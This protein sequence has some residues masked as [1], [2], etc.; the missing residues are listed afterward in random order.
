MGNRFSK[1]NPEPERESAPERTDT[2]IPIPEPIVE[3]PPE[4]IEITFGSE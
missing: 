2:I 4:E 3:P 1:P